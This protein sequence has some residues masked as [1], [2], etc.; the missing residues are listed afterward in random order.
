MV[1][2]KERMAGPRKIYGYGGIHVGKVDPHR[3]AVNWFSS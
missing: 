2:S 3:R 1:V